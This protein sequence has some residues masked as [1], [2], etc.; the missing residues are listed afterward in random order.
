MS[1]DLVYLCV[2]CF[3]LS[4]TSSLCMRPWIGWNSMLVRI[5]CNGYIPDYFC[6]MIEFE[7]ICCVCVHSCA[8]HLL[9]ACFKQIWKN[10]VTKILKWLYHKFYLFYTPRACYWFLFKE[11]WNFERKCNF[12]RK[13]NFFWGFCFKNVLIL[14]HPFT[15]ID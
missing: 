5:Y 12:E 13:S 8:Q 3:T 4:F 6:G 15:F 11:T 2:F 7:W 14:T 1:N 10:G 9:L